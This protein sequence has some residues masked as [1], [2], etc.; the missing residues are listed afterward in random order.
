MVTIFHK[1][2]KRIFLIIKLN[3]VKYW[4]NITIVITLEESKY[5]LI[6]KFFNKLTKRKK[7]RTRKIFSIE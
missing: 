7:I 4:K 2:T 5:K 6:T 3:E 1:L